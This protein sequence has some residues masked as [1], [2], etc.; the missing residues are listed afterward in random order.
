MIPEIMMDSENGELIKGNP[1][2]NNSITLTQTDCSKRK[3]IE[4]TFLFLFSL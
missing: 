2:N 1:E 4:N 3:L